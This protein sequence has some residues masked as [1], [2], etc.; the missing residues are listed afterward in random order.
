MGAGGEEGGGWE[1]R[2]EGRPAILVV[3]VVVVR[4]RRGW[5]GRVWGRLVRRGTGRSVE[6]QGR[7][8]REMRQRLT[9]KKTGGGGAMK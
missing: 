1:E 2:R 9:T 4:R 6:D 3:V 8:R 7:H 5:E